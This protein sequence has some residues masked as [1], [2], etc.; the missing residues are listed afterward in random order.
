VRAYVHVGGHRVIRAAA[1]DRLRLTG[2]NMQGGACE[3]AVVG[4]YCSSER[5]LDPVR[6]YEIQHRVDAQLW[7]ISNLCAVNNIQSRSLW[8]LQ[9]VDV[10]GYDVEHLVSVL[11]ASSSSPAGD[12]SGQ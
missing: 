5:H 3:L 11:Q 4:K 6:R 12:L 8:R 2:G 10:E 9:S 1:L 7:S